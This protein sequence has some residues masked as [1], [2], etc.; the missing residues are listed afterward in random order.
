MLVVFAVLA[1]VVVFV[2]AAVAIGRESSRLSAEAPRPVFDLDEA[3][4][5]VA[6]RVPFE[7]SAVLSHDDV[8]RLLRWNLTDLQAAAAVAGEE[9]HDGSDADTLP[10]SPLNVMGEHEAVAAVRVRAEAEG[11]EYRDSHVQAVLGAHLAYLE[12]IGAVGPAEL[13]EASTASGSAIGDE[14]ELDTE[15]AGKA[16]AGSDTMSAPEKGGGP[17]EQ[18][19]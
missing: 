12:V 11:L 10:P 6:N 17:A 4:N 1:L 13:V 16:V 3:V 5:W 7:V 2:I 8:R 15:S 19:L 18:T 9:A 14:R